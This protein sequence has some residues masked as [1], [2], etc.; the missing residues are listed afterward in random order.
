MSKPI[1]HRVEAEVLPD[2]H[3]DVPEVTVVSM[4]KAGKVE[5]ECDVEHPA[6]TERLYRRIDVAIGPLHQ[7]C[8]RQG[9]GDSTGQEMFCIDCGIGESIR[10][11]YHPLL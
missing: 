1:R 6:V 8:F 11:V 7:H 10:P 5:W 9:I 3:Y 4:I 2:A